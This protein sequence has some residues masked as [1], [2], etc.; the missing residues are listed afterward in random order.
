VDSVQ[1]GAEF[2]V[3]FVLVDV[4]K[5]LVEELLGQWAQGANYNPDSLTNPPTGQ[6]SQRL[7][8]FERASPAPLND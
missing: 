4:S 6:K 5:E 7:A 2:A 8:V 3:D 1:G